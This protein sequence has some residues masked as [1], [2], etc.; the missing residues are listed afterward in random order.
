MVGRRWLSGRRGGERWL[1]L[2]IY[3]LYLIVGE[4]C[5]CVCGTYGLYSDCIRGIGME[6]SW[7]F[8]S[9]CL[10]VQSRSLGSEIPVLKTGSSLGSFM[11][12]AAEDGLS[13]KL[14]LMMV[15]CREQRGLFVDDEEG[16][17]GG[18]R[19]RRK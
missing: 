17:E 14:I 19:E 16:G 8:M 5:A 12:W 13:R 18:E 2:D 10:L 1:W 11:I 15:V 6:G 3:L 7:L 9:S 4:V